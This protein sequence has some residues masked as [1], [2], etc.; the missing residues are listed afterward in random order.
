MIDLVAIPKQNTDEVWV[1]CES[2]IADALS[3]SGYALAEHMKEW[4][5]EGKMQLWFL[6]DTD[7]DVSERMYGVVITEIIQRPLHKCLNIKVMTGK[8]RDK[9]QHLVKKIEKFAWEN[10]CDL[11]E[12]VARPGWEKVLRRFGY[13]KSHVLLE[14][15][16]KEKK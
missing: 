2:M 16:N 7:A 15:H 5:K 11:M 4:I 6:W 13:S 14:K 12:L 10:D 3:R 9:W 8:H 1:H